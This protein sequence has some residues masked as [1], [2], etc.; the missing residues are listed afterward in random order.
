MLN[1]WNLGQGI[2]RGKDAL[3]RPIYMILV[4]SQKVSYKTSS[5]NYQ[6]VFIVMSTFRFF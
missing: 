4:V 1:W 3:Q 5:Q 6:H 2:L